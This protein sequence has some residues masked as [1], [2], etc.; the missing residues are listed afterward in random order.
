MKNNFDKIEIV[1]NKREILGQKIDNF[2][3]NISN[4]NKI[5]AVLMAMF[6]IFSIIFYCKD[7]A[8]YVRLNNIYETM[9]KE[10]EAHQLNVIY[11]NITP[12]GGQVDP[13]KNKEAPKYKNAKEA[14]AVAFA[15]LDKSSSYEIVGNGR[16]V[17]EAAGQTVEIVMSFTNIKYQTGTAFDEFVRKETQT[18]FGQTD[19]AQTIYKNG[20]KY[21]RN[22]SNIRKSGDRWIADF[23]G[24]FHDVTQSITSHP[25]YIINNDTIVANKSFS[26]ARDGNGNIAYYKATVLL[27]PKTSTKYYARNIKE[28]GGTTLP[29]FAYVQISCIIDRDGN[30]M[31]YSIQEEMTLSK[32]IV[33]EITTTTTNK[34]TCVVLS[35]N[36]NPSRPEIQI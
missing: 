13:S 4:I 34:T 20:R 35:T 12:N 18:N 14:V 16:T 17:A 21:K 8:E 9:L 24:N 3:F 1:E 29:S 31:S 32:V 6:I 5:I 28:E 36:Q 27:D 7:T 30:L 19:A 11:T 25:G 15:N 22:G 33:V 26:F 10:M 23:S 2:V